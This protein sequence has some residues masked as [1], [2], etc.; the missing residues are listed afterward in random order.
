MLRWLM[1][2]LL[3]EWRRVRQDV[4]DARR[5]LAPVVSARLERNRLADEQGLPRPKTKDTI[6]VNTPVEALALHLPS[7]P[8]NPTLLFFPLLLS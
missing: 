3:P 4:K 8:I 5:I 2:W 1:V 7:P 6:Q